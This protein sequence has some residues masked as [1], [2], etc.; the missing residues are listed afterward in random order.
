MSQPAA[1]PAV[2]ETIHPS[3]IRPPSRA[4][5]SRAATPG[6]IACPAPG[7]LVLADQDAIDALRHLQGEVRVAVGVP[8]RELDGQRLVLVRIVL[9]R[10]I[11]VCVIL[12]SVAEE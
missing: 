11:P 10:P 3:L 6:R 2:I 9:A 12:E 1:S 7:L 4:R 5:S 8:D